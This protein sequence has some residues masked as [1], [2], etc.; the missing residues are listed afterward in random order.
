MSHKKIECSACFSWQADTLLD[1]ILDSLAHKCRGTAF[2]RT[3]LSGPRSPVLA[4]F[5][6][7]WASGRSL[8]P[9][10][11]FCARNDRLTALAWDL[12]CLAI[13]IPTF[14]EGVR[15]SLLNVSNGDYDSNSSRA[16]F[17]QFFEDIDE[18]NLLVVQGW[19]A[20]ERVM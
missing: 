3:P 17:R 13:K 20:S 16:C 8:C 1:E 2:L 7:L 9:Q 6:L 11:A 14:M 12:S 18:T 19:C 5:G 4:Q 15:F 10:S